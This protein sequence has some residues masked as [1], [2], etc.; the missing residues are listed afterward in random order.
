[1]NENKKCG[2]R[3]EA[4]KRSKIYIYIYMSIKVQSVK[5]IKRRMAGPPAANIVHNIN[6][7]NGLRVNSATGYTVSIILISNA[8]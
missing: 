6:M 2:G 4:S 7:L 1:M 5:R 3:E 8:R